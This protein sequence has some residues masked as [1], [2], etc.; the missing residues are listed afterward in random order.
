MDTFSTIH[1]RDGLHLAAGDTG[2]LGAPGDVAPLVGRA[3]EDAA[4]VS[5]DAQS[6]QAVE[7]HAHA[8]VLQGRVEFDAHEVVAFLAAL[9]GLTLELLPLLEARGA[10]DKAVRCRH[11]A[12][13][14]LAAG[15]AGTRLIE[16]DRRLHD[17]FSFVSSLDGQSLQV[18][19]LQNSSLVSIG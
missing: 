4:I 14:V 8:G 5:S 6:A 11:A 12:T 2:L 10:D 17:R 15:D 18:W 9:L 19:R 16:L 1:P 7:R 3:F 13:G